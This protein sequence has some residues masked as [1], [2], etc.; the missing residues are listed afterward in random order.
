MYVSPEGNLMLLAFIRSE[1]FNFYQQLIIFKKTLS[2][3]L[4]LYFYVDD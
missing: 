3:S 1:A 2:I 4:K